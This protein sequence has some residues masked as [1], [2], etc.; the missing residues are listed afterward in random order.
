MCVLCYPFSLVLS[1]IRN[2]YWNIAHVDPRA[3]LT[4]QSGHDLNKRCNSLS[5]FTD[6]A[7]TDVL[8]IGV[9]H[10]LNSDISLFSVLLLVPSSRPPLLVLCLPRTLVI[11]QV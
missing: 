9:F 1:G 11:L 6:R 10:L 3:N 2:R 7:L 5:L 8:L 4:V